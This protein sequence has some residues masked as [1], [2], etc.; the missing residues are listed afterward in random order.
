[1]MHDVPAEAASYSVPA[2]GGF[3]ARMMRNVVASFSRV[4]AVSL[5]ALLLP[6]FLIHHLPVTTYA[7]WVLIIQLGAYV[8]YL[9]LGIQT[10]VSKF[11]AEHDARNDLAAASRHASAGLMLMVMAALLG[12][13]LTIAL[14]WRV[15]SL[16][17]EMPA[18][19][20]RDV[21][22]SVLLVGASLSFSLVCAVYSAVFL[23]LQRYWTPTII[24]ILNR[25][26]FTA[27]TI[28]IVSLHG[29]LIAMGLGVALVNVIAGL[30]QIAAWRNQVR[31]I[32]LSFSLVE[33]QVLR[34]VARFCSMQSI[35]TGAM[36]CISGLDVAIVGHFDYVQ[37]AYYSIA[38]MPTN[39]MLLIMSTLMNPLM[40]ASSALSTQRSPSQMGDFLGRATRYTAIMLLL[41]GLP[42]MVCGYPILRLWV[43]PSY[44]VNTLTYLRILVFANIIRNLCAP[45]A[46]MITAIGRQE[47][48]I[49]AA[50]SEAFVN[51]GCS[52]YLASRFGAI[53][54]ALGT[55]LG[56]F[57][58][59]LLHFTVTMRFTRTRLAITPYQLLFAGLL[60]PWIIALPSILFLPLWWR[61]S[62]GMGMGLTAVWAITTLALAWYVALTRTE[63]DDL[64]NLLKKP[65]AAWRLAY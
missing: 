57:V 46:T 30:I 33:A 31:H 17:A 43:G 28:V 53:G 7:A 61:S 16:F 52:I 62:G 2:P 41:S 4:I 13:I 63:R 19:L 1:M 51:L 24:T 18:N 58:S 9:D 59:I 11:V 26:A 23:G 45:Y 50:V 5:V 10:A 65:R 54:V 64:L 25:A 49:V 8:S 3:R 27:V 36:L 44:A 55:V 47:A 12:L 32:R 14:A 37:T 42:L 15:P 35:W 40:P 60:R 38:T 29:S 34:R 39:F 6:A 20:F 56:S 21:R 22:I 48:A